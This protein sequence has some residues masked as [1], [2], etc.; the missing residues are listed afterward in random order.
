MLVALGT[1]AILSLLAANVCRITS[2]RQRACF[3]ETSWGEALSAA[4][5]GADIAIAAIRAGTWTG[6]TGPDANGVRTY[7]TPVLSHDGEGNTSFYATIQVDSPASFMT[8]DG[9][10][11]RIRSTGTAL[12][13]GGSGAVSQDKLNNS[14]WHLSLQKNRDTGAAITGAGLV[15][16]TIEVIAMPGVLFPRAITLTNTIQATSGAYIDSF[17]SGDDTKS[18]GGLYDATKRQQNAA[19]GTLDS[20]G[21]NLNGMALYGDLMYTGPAVQGTDGVTGQIIT[22]FYET[23]Q[24]VAKPTWVSVNGVYGTFNGGTTLTSGPVGS[25]TR[26]KMSSIALNASSDILVLA[27]P[28]GGQQGQIEI[29]V[30]GDFKIA[31]SAQIISQPG[32]KVTFYVEGNVTSTGTGMV[33]QSNRA[34]NFVVEGVTPTDGSARTYKLSGT[35]DFTASIYAPAYDIT[36]G[37]GGIYSGAFVGKTMNM[38]GGSAAIH[39]DEAL[40]HAGGGTLYTVASWTEDVR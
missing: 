13:S 34:A 27:P 26:Y 14:L 20:T 15:S 31:G 33:N 16:R 38:S 40:G 29:W 1:I 7:Q 5:S 30:T 10:F 22:P 28:A 4:E 37:G 39:Y 23:L 3:Q 2:Q 36:L 25:P 11:Y 18:T 32:V 8:M 21:A 35:A 12:L 17:D 19:L 9:A 24:P 6:W